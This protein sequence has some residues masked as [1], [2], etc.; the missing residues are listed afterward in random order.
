MFAMAGVEGWSPGSTG[1]DLAITV[2]TIMFALA[3]M[4]LGLGIAFRIRWLQDWGRD[5]LVQSTINGA[6]VG[7]LV[8]LFGSTG[9][10]MLLM[11][12]VID[13]QNDY[14]LTQ[15]RNQN[16]LE[17]FVKTDIGAQCSG[18]LRGTGGIIT[19][20]CYALIYLYTIEQTLET[21]ILDLSE[22]IFILALLA[23]L[24]INLI[25]VSFNF[26]AGLEVFVGIFSNMLEV[27]VM[28]ATMTMVQA[29][30]I[31]FVDSVA[32]P[33]LLPVGLILRSFFMTRKLGG[34]I[35]AIAIGLG[36]VFPL[37]F[38]LDGRMMSDNYNVPA[39][40]VNG[41]ITVLRSSLNNMTNFNDTFKEPLPGG[42][43]TRPGRNFETD[44]RCLLIVQLHSG[45][46][47][48]P[49][50]RHVCVHG[51][52]DNDDSHTALL[53]HH[54]NACE[55]TGAG[56]PLRLRIQRRVVRRAVIVV[57]LWDLRTSRISN[58][59]C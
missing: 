46:N 56:E 33:I 8:L 37:T 26:F 45:S 36:V 16:P 58:S 7:G 10:V 9:I 23:S 24:N 11:N 25:V 38:V 1:Y 35:M 57:I 55:H 28:L 39:N 49:L 29:F 19:P 2:V 32:I 20:S 54:N 22:L 48:K 53:Q 6:L 51:K 43:D 40:A 47:A 12:D 42:K 30:F 13:V 3:G 59:P 27:F 18:A 41:N 44:G 5:E 15:Y 34:A 21:V 52:H 14:V 4:A 17:A 50:G 31:I